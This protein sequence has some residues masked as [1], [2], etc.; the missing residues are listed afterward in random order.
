[1]RANVCVFYVR[2]YLPAVRVHANDY[3]FPR[4]PYRSSIERLTI[5]KADSRRIT[6][7]FINPQFRRLGIC[8]ARYN[9]RARRVTRVYCERVWIRARTEIGIADAHRE[10][11][12]FYRESLVSGKDGDILPLHLRS[13]AMK[14]Q[15]K[16]RLNYVSTIFFPREKKTVSP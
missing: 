9:K 5:N 11:S 7:P 16:R 15:S 4:A 8:R 3:R 13:R 12:R 10:T 14:V 2:L 1:L 6:R